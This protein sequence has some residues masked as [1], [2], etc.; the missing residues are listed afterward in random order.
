MDVRQAVLGEI[1]IRSGRE[2]AFIDVGV[3]VR[4]LILFDK[5]IVRS[6]RLRELPL[7]VRTFGKT[8]I[9]ELLNSAH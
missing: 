5:V 7:L 8:G 2:V 9:Q 3:L 1:A 6:Y 4:R